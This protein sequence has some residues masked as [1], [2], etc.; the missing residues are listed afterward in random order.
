MYRIEI[1]LYVGLERF[2]ERFADYEIVATLSP[3]LSWSYI[4]ELIPL[5]SDEARIYYAQDVLNRRHGVR[6]LRHQISCIT[7]ERC[8]I[9][10]SA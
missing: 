4:I 10:N 2:A 1:H 8:Q 7:F 9:A 6:E 3:Q 5:K